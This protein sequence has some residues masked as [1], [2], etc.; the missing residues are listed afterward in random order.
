MARIGEADVHVLFLA[1]L[2]HDPPVA[3][4]GRRPVQP[5]VDD[6]EDDDEDLD[7][8]DDLEDDDDFDDEDLEEFEDFDEDEE[9]E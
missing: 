4:L 2:H 8:E 1:A 7:D 3:P 5:T 6:D 9:K